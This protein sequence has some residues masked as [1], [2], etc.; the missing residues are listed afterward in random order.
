MMPK[1]PPQSQSSRRCLLKSAATLGSASLV[2]AGGSP[3]GRAEEQLPRQTHGTDQDGLLQAPE[4]PRSRRISEEVVTG[5]SVLKAPGY[6]ETK[7][8][9][10]IQVIEHVFMEEEDV[11]AGFPVMRTKEFKVDAS[12]KLAFVTVSGFEFWF[13]TAQQ[14]MWATSS[15]YGFHAGLDGDLTTGMLTVQARANLRFW[16]KVDWDW[17]WRC[18]VVVQCYGQI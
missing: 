11:A 5:G 17:T 13:G 9:S 7:K 10:L 18:H 16:G 12:T 1:K 4:I 15:R 14:E 3:T 8:H 2:T 6:S